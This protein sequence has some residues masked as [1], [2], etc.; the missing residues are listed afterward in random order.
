MDDLCTDVWQFET[1]DEEDASEDLNYIIDRALK[2]EGSHERAYLRKLWDGESWKSIKEKLLTEGS[3]WHV[4]YMDGVR[5]HLINCLDEER[6]AQLC[7][8]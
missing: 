1:S 5:Q 3:A 6:K 8:G 2:F 7:S 4:W